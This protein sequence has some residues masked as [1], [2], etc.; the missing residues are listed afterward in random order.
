[1]ATLIE[2]WSYLS[3]SVLLFTISSIE[4]FAEI[5]IRSYEPK[6]H[7]YHMPRGKVL[8]Q[9]DQLSR[10]KIFIISLWECTYSIL[11]SSQVYSFISRYHIWTQTHEDKQNIHIKFNF[12]SWLVAFFSSLQQLLIYNSDHES[13]S[14][15]RDLYTY[16]SPFLKYIQ[17]MSDTSLCTHMLSISWLCIS[18]CVSRIVVGSSASF[19]I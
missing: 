15:L 4:M 19:H 14:I 6:A 7:R 9:L 8:L 12:N 10:R 11:D 16:Y 17:L 3:S 5:H 1:M 18:T 13:I 2:K